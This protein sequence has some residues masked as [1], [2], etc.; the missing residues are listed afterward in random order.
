MEITEL[1]QAVNQLGA[2]VD[3]LASDGLVDQESLTRMLREVR[4]LIAD[5]RL[6]DA[7]IT[8]HLVKLIPFGAT[9]EHRTVQ[10]IGTLE[11]KGG[12]DRKGFDQLR[13]IGAAAAKMADEYANSLDENTGELVPKPPGPFAFDVALKTA[14]LC[15]AVAPSFTGWRSGVAKSLGLDLD[16]YAAD[17]GK[18]PLS[19]IIR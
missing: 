7:T 1:R 6:L 4:D 11:V 8:G 19:I 15:G 12:K 10:G 18:S 16:D 9:P 14:E 2:G 3:K 5:C 17:L 13:L